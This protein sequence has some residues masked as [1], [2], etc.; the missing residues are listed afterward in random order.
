MKHIE[1]L[2]AVGVLVTSLSP[3]VL[4][5]T[6]EERAGARATAEQGVK[7]YAEGRWAQAADLMAR[8]EKLVHAPTHLLYQAQSEE[9]LGHLVV[10]LEL[11]RKILREKLAPGAPEA[12][13]SA[14]QEAQ[15]RADVLQPRLSQVSIVV[16]GRLAGDTVRVTMD[17][18]PVPEALVGVP[19]PVDPGTHRFE[20]TAEGMRTSVT[21]LELREGSTETVVLTLQGTQASATTPATS[22]EQRSIAP[23]QSTQSSGM[24]PLKIAGFVGL[25]L[26]AIGLGVGTIFAIK[27]KGLRDDAATLYAE[28]LK[29]DNACYRTERG[30]VDQKD[31]DA[32]SAR[33]IAIV[34]LVAGGVGVAAGVTMLLLAPSKQAPKTAFI[35]PYFTADGAGVWG[36]F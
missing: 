21:K 36:R 12:F 26:G 25:G 14:Q 22:P 31:S 13:V 33:T 4:A 6:E 18:R 32:D 23:A 20:A 35:A 8:A 7:A 16:Q 30:P 24:H 29:S 10:A 17:E 2:I 28:C 19:H 15:R 27:S 11:Y 5:Q 9:A 1:R 3:S 34:G